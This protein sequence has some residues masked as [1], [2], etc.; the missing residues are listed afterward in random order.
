MHVHV[1][2]AASNRRGDLYPERRVAIYVAILSLAAM[3]TCVRMYLCFGEK[4]GA[5][6]NVMQV[7]TQM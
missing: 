3:C 5:R 1:S 2:V 6:M 4:V 7:S